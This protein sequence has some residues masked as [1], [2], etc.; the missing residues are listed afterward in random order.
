[1]SRSVHRWLTVRS[2]QGRG[3]PPDGLLLV[4]SVGCHLTRRQATRAATAH[5][6]DSWKRLY[7]RGYRVVPILIREAEA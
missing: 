3:W 1:M 2:P 6:G 4:S 5:Y 7:R